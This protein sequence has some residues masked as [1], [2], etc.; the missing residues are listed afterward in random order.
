[1]GFDDEAADLLF[2]WVAH[3]R[4]VKEIGRAE[5]CSSGSVCFC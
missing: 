4:L 3:G 5:R 2:Q 1:M